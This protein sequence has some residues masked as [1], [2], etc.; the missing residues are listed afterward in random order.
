MCLVFCVF[1]LALFYIITTF[2][3]CKL[4]EEKREAV[5]GMIIFIAAIT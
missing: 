3:V 2:T 1:S 5:E 4:R